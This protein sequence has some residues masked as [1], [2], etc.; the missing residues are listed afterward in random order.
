MRITHR[1]LRRII[2]EE[3]LNLLR[4]S[5][6]TERH[7]LDTDQDGNVDWFE[8]EQ[9]GSIYGSGP[10]AYRL[11]DSPLTDLA[12]GIEDAIQNAV[13]MIDLD[14]S[15]NPLTRKDIIDFVARMLHEQR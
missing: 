5:L 6:E 14:F 12:A 3:K 11:G 9:A 13:G 2:R 15:D 7:P 1:Q 8:I 10:G 4:E